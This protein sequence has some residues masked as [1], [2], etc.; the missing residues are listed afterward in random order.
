ML[1]GMVEALFRILFGGGERLLIGGGER[2]CFFND[3]VFSIF[4]SLS[5]TNVQ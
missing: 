5:L 1:V 4:T 2:D 3:E